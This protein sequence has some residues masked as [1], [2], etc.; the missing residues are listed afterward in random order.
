MGQAFRQGPV[1]MTSLCGD[2]W[3]F[4]WK[5]QRLDWSLRTHFQD[6]LVTWLAPLH[7]SITAGLLE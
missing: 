5:M 6:G 3:G 7:M 1:V 4:S 2:I